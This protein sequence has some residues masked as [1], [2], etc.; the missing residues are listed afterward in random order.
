MVF[1]SSHRIVH[2]SRTNKFSDDIVLVLE[3]IFGQI[4]RL[5]EQQINALQD[6]HAGSRVKVRL[7]SRGCDLLEN[8][9]VRRTRRQ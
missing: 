9:S 1:S 5:V 8:I 3:P 7:S 6:L 2:V 4:I